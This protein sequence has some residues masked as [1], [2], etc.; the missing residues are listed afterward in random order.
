MQPELGLLVSL[1]LAVVAVSSQRTSLTLSCAPQSKPGKCVLRSI[2]VQEKDVID[3]A[4]RPTTEK[5]VI[6]ENSQ[7]EYLPEVLFNRFPQLESLHA[8]GVGLKKFA[9]DAFSKSPNLKNLDVSANLVGILPQDVFGTCQNL[10]AID[11]AHNRLHLFNAIELIGCN[12]LHRLN[13]SSNQLIFINWEPLNDLRLLEHIDLSNNLISSVMV[14]RYAK[15][16]VAR[17]NHIHKLATDPN[18]FIFMLEYLDA[19]RNRLNNIETLA[20]FGKMTYIDLSYNRLLS[21]DFALFKNMRSLRELNLAHNNIFAVST[22]DVQP[23]ALRLV[24]LSNN[25]LTRLSVDDT[26]GISQVEQLLLNN[27]YLVKFE[28]TKGQNLFPRLQSITLSGNDWACPDMEAML[29]EFGSKKVTVKSTDENCAT[30]LV[31]KRGL[32]CR[33]LGTSFDELVLLESQKLSEMQQRSP[34]RMDV[35]STIKPIMAD[36]KQAPRIETPVTVSSKQPTNQYSG[37]IEQLSKSLR[38]TMSRLVVVEADLKTSNSEKS[39]LKTSLDRAQAEVKALNEKLARCKS[40]VN[41]RTGQTVLI[42]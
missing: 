40:T 13:V 31:K 6:F 32:C 37:E 4:T 15:K 20:R 26:R 11:I 38:E 25:E 12:K 33:D 21:V 17:N 10:E 3:G 24:D 30:H 5:T 1:L 9:P 27:N 39:T 19:S 35:T 41:Q 42:D 34:V 28:V 22:S 29:V 7:L 18:S 8:S 2:K 14:P 23:I 16:I 36:Q